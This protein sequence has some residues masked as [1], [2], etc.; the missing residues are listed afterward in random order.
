MR[1]YTRT[2]DGGETGTFGGGRVP[3]AHPRIAAYGETDELNSTLGWCAAAAADAGGIVADLGARLAR[4][5]S[6]LFV[7]GAWLATPPDAE[8]GTRRHLPDWPDGAPAELE[9]EMDAWEAAL[10]PLKSFILPGGVELAARLHV[11]RTVCRR[12]ERAVALLAA[13]AA[14]AVDPRGLIYLNRLSDWLFMA[15]RAANAAAGR[16]DVPWRPTP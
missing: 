3:K 9:R 11:A 4:E 14:Q 8:A 15:A 1:I 7:L 10:P 12:A 16:A 6:R 2:G 13:D 5:Q